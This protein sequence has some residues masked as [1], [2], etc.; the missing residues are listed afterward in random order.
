MNT[1]YRLIWDDRRNMLVIVDEN[2]SAR[3]KNRGRRVRRAV[4]PAVVFSAALA[5]ALVAPWDGEAWGGN[6][7]ALL[8]ATSGATVSR[9]TGAEASGDL[10]LAC[11]DYAITGR[12]TG[13]VSNATNNV[14]DGAIAVGGGTNA[15]S[16]TNTQHGALATGI[17]AI[18]VGSSTTETNA[19]GVTTE[20]PGALS[21]GKGAIALGNGAEAAKL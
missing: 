11:G 10:A 4:L 9:P 17:G 21:V 12:K 20:I 2:S 6:V 3:G 18:A 19:S 13:I 15:T 16:A 5:G 1:A 14:S 7:C 8:P